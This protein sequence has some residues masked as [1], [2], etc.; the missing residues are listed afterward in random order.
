MARACP[1]CHDEPASVEVRIGPVYTK[2][3][4]RCIGSG[5]HMM[6]LLSKFLG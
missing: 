2:V 6:K 3:G 1:I 4:P 5:L